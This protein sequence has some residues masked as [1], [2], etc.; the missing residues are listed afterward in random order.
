MKELPPVIQVTIN[1]PFAPTITTIEWLSFTMKDT[2]ITVPGWLLFVY[3]LIGQCIPAIDYDW[4]V[5][6][7]TQDPPEIVT[8]VGVAF[9]KGFALAD[10]IFY[11]PLLGIGLWTYERHP[12]YL[13]AALG[14]T[15]YWPIV[16][17]RAAVSARHAPGWS[18]NDRPYHIVLPV[19]ILWA[20]W[21]LFRLQPASHSLS[22][23]S[24]TDVRG[25]VAEESQRLLAQDPQT[26]GGETFA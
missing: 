12:L 2:T 1:P 17:F 5:T 14:I 15:I 7:G 26:S 25:Q 19:I 23:A 20:L 11:V 22:D 24:I 9:W 21:A 16:V 18:L 13:S 10:L 8:E 6:M 3:L 4:G